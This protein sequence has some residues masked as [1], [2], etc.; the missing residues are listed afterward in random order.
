[1]Q[2][3]DLCRA[4]QFEKIDPFVVGISNYMVGQGRYASA[5]PLTKNMF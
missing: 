4:S 5:H 1:M 2:L 3:L